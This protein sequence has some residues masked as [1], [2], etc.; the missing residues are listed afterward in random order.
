LPRGKAF[1]I[2]YGRNETTKPCFVAAY[3]LRKPW[4]GNAKKL[5]LGIGLKHRAKPARA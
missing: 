5:I 1:E 3:F 2:V 4:A